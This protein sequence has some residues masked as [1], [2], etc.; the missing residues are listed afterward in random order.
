MGQTKLPKAA[1]AAAAA[2]A[3]KKPLFLSG[4]NI[5]DQRAKGEE[6]CELWLVKHLHPYRG[7][8]DEEIIRAAEKGVEDFKHIG[9][10][11]YRALGH[12]VERRLA[13]KRIEPQFLELVCDLTQKGEDNPSAFVCGEDSLTCRLPNETDRWETEESVKAALTVLPQNE[14]IQEFA[15]LYTAETERG[16]VFDESAVDV[17]KRVARVRDWQA[18]KLLA[19][20]Q[21]RAKRA[22]AHRGG[23]F[24]NLHKILRDAVG[25]PCRQWAKIKVA[26]KSENTTEA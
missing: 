13:R 25:A 5:R 9:R 26:D 20:L 7:W 14:L 18:G 24:S 4:K 15:R 17:V 21:E 23:P 8:S 3:E 11:F 12:E 19:Q 1:A 10:K 16:F 6:F 2:A 22:L